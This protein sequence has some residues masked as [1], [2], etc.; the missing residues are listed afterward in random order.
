MQDKD[1]MVKDYCNKFKLQSGLLTWDHSS[2]RSKAAWDDSDSK[3]GPMFVYS[4]MMTTLKPYP[5]PANISELIII[6]LSMGN[7]LQ[8]A[9]L[10][11]LWLG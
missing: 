3:D 1:K 6:A 5:Q 8:Y 2:I 11:K 9:C 10:E 7:Y 4:F